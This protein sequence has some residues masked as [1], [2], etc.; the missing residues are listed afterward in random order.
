MYL[1]FR[2][3]QAIWYVDWTFMFVKYT[4]FSLVV[5]SLMVVFCLSVVVRCLAFFKNQICLR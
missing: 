5:L 2:E 4:D 1:T 3:L